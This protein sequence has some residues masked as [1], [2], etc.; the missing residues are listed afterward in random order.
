MNTFSGQVLI[1]ED[2]VN[3]REGLRDI[4]LKDGHSVIGVGSGEEALTL[5]DTTDFEVAIVDIRMPG[6]SGIDLLQTIRDRW[7]HICVIILTGHGDLESAMAAIKAGAHDYLLKP[8][9]PDTIRRTVVEALKISRRQKEQAHLLASLRT[10]L[11]RLDGMTAETP[12]KTPPSPDTHLLK[13]GDLH[14]DLRSH[15]VHRNSR[16]IH[17]SPTEFKVLTTL[18]SYK[19]EVVEYT[20]LAQLSLGYEA[21]LWEA[22]ELLKR[23]IFSLRHKIEP[24]PN[25]PRYIL[26]VRGVGYRLASPD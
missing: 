1:V 10:S 12:S 4:L 7:Q 6:L 17:L 23:H 15:Q 5:L 14:I 22:K 24:D 3:I 20:T 16:P 26:N 25:S 18:A 2:E 9:Q 21:A 13:I 8:A 19:D 11:N